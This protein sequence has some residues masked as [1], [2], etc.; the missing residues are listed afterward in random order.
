MFLKKII[1]KNLSFILLISLFFISFYLKSQLVK[2][3]AYGFYPDESR[4]GLLIDG[5]QS[6][7]AKNN[8]TE[9]LK[10]IFL[11]DARPGYG[12]LY[13]PVAYFIIKTQNPA[14][15]AG[16]F[17]N[18]FLISL[19]TVFIFIIIKRLYNLLTG[20]LASF[21]FLFSM[22][23]YTYI[24]HML[25]A[26]GALFFFLLSGVIYVFTRSLILTGISV[27][28]SFATHP[29][30]YFY[31]T[32]LFVIFFPN[33]NLKNILRRIINFGGGVIITV[34]LL[35]FISRILGM[36]GTY[37]A[38]ARGLSVS[39][40][41]GDFSPALFFF[42]DYVLANDGIFGIAILILGIFSLYNLY[43]N[44]NKNSSNKFFL[45]YTI[46]TYIFLEM[47]SFIFHKTVLYGRTIRNFY[48]L[49]FI[50]A[51][52]FIANFLS[53][54][55][56]NKKINIF[57]N[58]KIITLLFI[59]LFL[60][61]WHTRFV[62]LKDNIYHKDFLIKINA[63]SLS[64]RNSKIESIISFKGDPKDN[65]PYKIQNKG[66]FLLNTYLMYPYFGNKTIGCQKKILLKEK[67]A[68]V[69]YEP[70]V[71]EGFSKEMRK[72]FKTDPPY[73]TLIYCR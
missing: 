22:S 31:I 10:T 72:S 39:V 69:S 13:F 50:L 44:K 25:P 4:F 6:Y 29:G 67:H 18:A 61:N 59:G 57:I 37:I 46:T 2:E 11:L 26:D 34:I 40:N 66:Y 64:P 30:I 5:V 36:K 23:S 24:R 60:I 7:I 68:L 21:F 17:Y 1:I 62:Q 53:E 27:G 51:A 41:Q 55:F 28:L 56:K 14:S 65:S 38:T 35:E 49:F 15:I 58:K 63:I 8:I 33:F 20:F 32:P 52:I 19:C 70:Y 54:N 42:I 48:I 45:F 47:M 73:Y 12:I 3:T 71:F 43:K 16:Q 9:Y